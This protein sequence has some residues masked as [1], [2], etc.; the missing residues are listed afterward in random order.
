MLLTEKTA[1]FVAVFYKMYKMYFSHDI[2]FD[3][4]RR[5]EVDGLRRCLG[6]Y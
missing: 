1:A 4:F 6:P 5:F 2:F 3:V